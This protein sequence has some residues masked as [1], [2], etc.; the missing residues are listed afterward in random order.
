MPPRRAEVRRRGV[1]RPSNG[2]G[3]EPH[4]WRVRPS[5]EVPVDRQAGARRRPGSAACFAV[6]RAS[7]RPRSDS[8]RH[9]AIGKDRTTGHRTPWTGAPMPVHLHGV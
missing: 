3:G 2:G 5:T 8:H 6:W 9:R 7:A 4:V 1:A